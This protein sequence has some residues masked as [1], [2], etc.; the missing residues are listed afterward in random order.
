MGPKE[1]EAF[2]KLKNLFETVL[3]MYDENVAT[4]VYGIRA[5]LVQIQKDVENVIAYASISLSETKKQYS[6]AARKCFEVL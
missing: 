5:V 1:L 4:K 3:K 2:Y 6:I